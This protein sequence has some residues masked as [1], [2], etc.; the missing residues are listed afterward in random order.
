MKKD[1]I[2]FDVETTGLD[3]KNDYIIQLALYKIDGETLMLKDK[4]DY[5]I[6][7][8]H[9]FTISEKLLKPMESRKNF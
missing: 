7:P 8:Q 5:Y 6:L 4:K 1:I 9:K 3:Q 2:A